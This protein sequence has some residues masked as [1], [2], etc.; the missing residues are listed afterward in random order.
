[1]K[2]TTIQIEKYEGP[3]DLLLALI[4]KNELDIYDIPISQITSQYIEYIYLASEFDIELA[5]EFIVM[6]AQL[7]EIKSKTLLPPED[8]QDDEEFDPRAELIKRLIEYKVFK[9]ISEYI[10]SYEYDYAKTLSK[11]ASYYPQLNY[12]KEL[13][14]IDCEVLSTVMRNILLRHKVRCGEPGDIYSV[15][16]GVVSVDEKLERLRHILKL[17]NEFMFSELFEDDKSV[18][19][20]VASLLAILEMFK[21][22]AIT[23]SQD[24]TYHDIYIAKK[25]AD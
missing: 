14:N 8:V 6:A 12:A 20:I 13:D 3:L 9:V 16:L 5:S 18:S 21:R 17:K 25:E 2:Q 10:K 19:S 24:K 1:M 4:A 22:N 7:I 23:F 15:D 11:D